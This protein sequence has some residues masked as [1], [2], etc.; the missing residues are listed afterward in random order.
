MV[1]DKL[2]I[3][4][5]DISDLNNELALLKAKTKNHKSR[6]FL[7]TSNTIQN[8]FKRILNKITHL[9]KNYELIQVK[10]ELELSNP[11]GIVKKEVILYYSDV[12]LEDAKKLAK[13]D[14]GKNFTVIHAINIIPGKPYYL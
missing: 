4:L 7:I 11:M 1:T 9:G 12:S 6:S 5:E 3:Y 14:A 2:P 10:G 13:R 8:R